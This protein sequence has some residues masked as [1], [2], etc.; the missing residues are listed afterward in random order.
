MAK[1]M[2]S[3]KSEK[4]NEKSKF[5]RSQS[6]KKTEQSKLSRSQR[7]KAIGKDFRDAAIARDEETRLQKKS[8]DDIFVIDTTAS[9]ERRKRKLEPKKKESVRGP[10]KSK[11]AP[12]TVQVSFCFVYSAR[13]LS[14]VIVI[15]L[16]YI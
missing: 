4:K 3:S 14:V 2:M 5:S 1:V 7:E 15:I 13:K 9:S 12:T 10:V 11:S 8:D 16:V 6:E